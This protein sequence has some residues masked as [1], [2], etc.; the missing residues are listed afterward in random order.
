M[1]IG[2]STSVM[3]R[4]FRTD[5]YRQGV[6]FLACKQYGHRGWI[7]TS[8]QEIKTP[9]GDIARFQRPNGK[10]IGEGNKKPN[11]TPTP[12]VKPNLSGSLDNNRLQQFEVMGRIAWVEVEG[13]PF[14]LWTD[15]TFTRIAKQS[16]EKSGSCVMIQDENVLF[17]PKRT[18][19]ETQGWVPEFTDEYESEDDNSM[20]EE[21]E[22]KKNGI[23]DEHSD[24]EIVPESLFEDGELENNHV[25]GGSMVGLL[26][27]VIKVGQVMGFKME[28]VIANLEELIGTQGG[29]EDIREEG[30]NTLKVEEL[31]K[32]I[33]PVVLTQSPDS[34]LDI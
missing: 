33:N 5:N 18:S 27:D 12:S 34:L 1:L 3:L 4:N 10:N 9:C 25:D 28:G 24:G 23:K 15:N 32:V 14:K 20:D 19:N 22:V 26:E 13:V 6:L 11:V 29:K 31:A 7:L 8:V 17:H 2:I 16:V 21:G 30:W